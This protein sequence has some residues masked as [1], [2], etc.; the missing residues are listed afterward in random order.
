MI[1]FQ[2]DI[3][4]QITEYAE[5][6]LQTDLPIEYSFSTAW[7]GVDKANRRLWANPGMAWDG[8]TMFPDFNWILESSLW[9]DIL[10]FLI[11][12]GAIREDQNHAIDREL[13]RA[14]QLLGGPE[15][16]GR[17]ADTLLKIRSGY[18]RRA[19]HLADQ[20]YGQVRPIYQ[21][22]YGKRTRIR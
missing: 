20:K 19:T 9:H 16:R 2:T 15:S 11:A 14:I 8:A 4:Y 1:T 10:H 21:L 5:Y 17:I 6:Y 7:Y 22:S 13:A 3:K 12:K 18:V